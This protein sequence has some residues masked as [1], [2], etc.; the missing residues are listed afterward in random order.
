MAKTSSKSRQAYYSMYKA[1]N[2]WKTNRERK[3][4]KLLKLH[5]NNKQL[6]EAIKNIKYRR[7]TPG[8]TGQWSRTNIEIAQ[9]FKQVTGYASHDLFNSNEKT[10]SMALSMR[11]RRQ[12]QKPLGKVSFQ[13]GARAHDKVGNLVW[14]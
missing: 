11:G 6:E 13:L 5:P 8:T 1:T 3:L 14:S 10:Q 9:L 7:K 4:L 2:R 12:P